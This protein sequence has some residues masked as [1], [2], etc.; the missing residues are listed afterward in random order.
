MKNIVEAVVA[1]RQRASLLSSSARAEYTRIHE[2]EEHL[3]DLAQQMS[4]LADETVGVVRDVDAGLIV[5]ESDLSAAV[6]TIALMTQILKHIMDLSDGV[7]KV[8]QSQMTTGQDMAK[9]VAGAA[10]GSARIATHV[11]A[12][13]QAIK[14]TRPHASGQSNVETKLASLTGQLCEARA[15]FWR[16]LQDKT[17]E[18]QLAAGCSLLNKSPFVN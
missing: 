16:G 4:G 14:T 15:H 2:A 3:T 11:A 8:V 1:L 5:P 7:E 17:T 9:A 10:R 6:Q 13:S 18:G 12:L